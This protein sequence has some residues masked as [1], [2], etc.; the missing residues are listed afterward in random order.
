MRL[1]FFEKDL[2]YYARHRDFR[3]CAYCDL[4][5][6]S[7]WDQVRSEALRHAAHSDIV[8]TAS[9]T[10]DGTRINDD[11]LALPHPLRVFYDLD[12]PITLGQLHTAAL[13]YISAEQISQFDLYLSFTGGQ[14]LRELEQRYGARMARPLYGCVDPDSYRRVAARPEFASALSYLGTYAA[15]RQA[16]LDSLLLE[17]A[18]R[19]AELQF[20]LAG[21]LYPQGWRWPEN[22]RRIEHVAPYDH[23]ALY[24]SSRATLNI[25]RQEM[26][27][28]GYCPS[29][30]F[31]EAAACGTPILTDYWEGLDTFFDPERELLPV[32]TTEDVLQCLDMPLDELTQRAD[33]A[34]QR[35]LAEHT[36]ESRAAEFLAHCNEARQ[37]QGS[38]REVLA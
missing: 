9:Y 17:A 30:R 28:A 31:F 6:Y 11:I 27:A 35:T 24:S 1:V 10:P 12:T 13:D 25:T 26:A 37:G 14:L 33:R 19:R 8:V 29:G 16:K 34:R 38:Q 36:G 32:R 5:L 3:S 4:R 21:S 23:P 18:R 15:G 20:I 2:P 22:V 7:D